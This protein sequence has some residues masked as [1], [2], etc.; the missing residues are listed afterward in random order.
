MQCHANA[1]HESSARIFFIKKVGLISTAILAVRKGLC[2]HLQ[3]GI[4]CGQI[5]KFQKNHPISC[6]NSL[7]TTD[8]WG[9][10]FSTAAMTSST[11]VS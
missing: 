3:G 8:I 11:E 9:P 4:L 6:N 10:A 2:N 7:T 1:A 5:C